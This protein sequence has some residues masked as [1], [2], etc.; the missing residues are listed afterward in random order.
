MTNRNSEPL[1][2]VRNPKST[3]SE[4]IE[5][6]VFEPLRQVGMREGRDFEIYETRSPDFETNV[7][8]MQ[9]EIPA[10]VRIISATGDGTGAQLVNASLRGEKGWTLGFAPGGN[11]NDLHS[12][13]TGET[14]SILDLIDEEAPTVDLRPL[15]IER[16]GEYWRH[17]AA[18]FSLGWAALA[19]GEF[20]RPE[21]RERMR[22][23]NH[24]T[25]LRRSLSYVALNYLRHGRKKLPEFTVNGSD[26]HRRSTD[27]IAA[28]NP[29]I[30]KLLHI[31]HDYSSRLDFGA[32]HDIDVSN[33]GRNGSFIQG[34]LAKRTPLDRRDEMR[35]A[36]ENT[37]RLPA[38]T[39]GEF[40]YLEARD[41]FVYKNPADV[42][43]V[44][45]TTGANTV[46]ELARAA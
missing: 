26:K 13:H 4:S 32:R 41:I 28:V 11:F 5:H 23:A 15:T 24:D 42:V 43:R 37:A 10:G 12:V 2:I 40:T 30:A 31:E 21:I 1:Y 8:H 18:Y 45:H 27:I 33:P 46:P 35:I 9:S 39:E 38:Q 3:R 6:V 29:R 36:F 19:T 20:S 22:N 25:R 34:I 7:A 16:D 17:S 44:I 14:T